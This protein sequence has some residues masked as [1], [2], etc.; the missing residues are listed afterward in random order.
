MLRASFAR[1]HDELQV[2]TIMSGGLWQSSDL[3][4]CALALSLRQESVGQGLMRNIHT[5]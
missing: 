1:V 2:A 3:A 4:P 5:Q